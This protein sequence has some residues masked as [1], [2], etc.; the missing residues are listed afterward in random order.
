MAQLINLRE[1]EYQTIVTE[2]AKMHT[3][4]LQNVADVIT[5]MKTLVTSGDAFS[6]NLTS[7]KMTDMLDLLSNDVMTLLQQAFQD[8]EAGVA[9]MITSAT[10]TD[11]ACG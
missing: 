4:Q 10:I 9:N 7:Q 3:D 1:N 8:S 11:S 5:E 2:L 6:A